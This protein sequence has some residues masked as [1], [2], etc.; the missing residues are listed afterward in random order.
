MKAEAQNYAIC[1]ISRKLSKVKVLL[2]RYFNVQYL[3]F[4]LTFTAEMEQRYKQFA[5]MFYVFMLIFSPAK[6]NS[7]SK[8]MTQYKRMFKE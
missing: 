2:L 5:V 7:F 4:R 8:K 1:R 3:E 6:Y